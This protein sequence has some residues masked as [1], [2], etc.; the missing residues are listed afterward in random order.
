MILIGIS[1]MIRYV[2]HVPVGHVYVFFGK[3]ENKDKNKNTV[4]VPFLCFIMCCMFF[5]IPLYN[6]NANPILNIWLASPHRGVLFIYL[7][8]YYL[9]TSRL[10]ATMLEAGFWRVSFSLSNLPWCGPFILYCGASIPL[11]LQLFSEEFL[12]YTLVHLPCP[13]EDVRLGHS[14]ASILNCLLK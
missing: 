11:V 8:I 13:R 3:N 5:Y 4:Q 6:L 2:E 7:S 12:P 1:L 9:D 10:W 14:Y